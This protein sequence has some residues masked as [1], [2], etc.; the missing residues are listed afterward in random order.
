[1][2]KTRYFQLEKNKFRIS[3]NLINTFLTGDA[4]STQVF[5]HIVRDE[6]HL[7]VA[8]LYSDKLQQFGQPYIHILDPKTLQLI[9]LISVQEYLPETTQ[10][11][12]YLSLN[13]SLTEDYIFLTG[14][15]VCQ[16]HVFCEMLQNGLVAVNIGF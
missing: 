12:F 10:N 7:A 1:M 9:K 3:S 13:L 2:A 15:Q 6:K 4:P 5:S 16:F 11:K 8:G 14:L